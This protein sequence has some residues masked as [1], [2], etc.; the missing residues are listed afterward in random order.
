MTDTL[1]DRLRPALADRYDIDREVG[2]GGMA[3]VFRAR[4]VRH[5]RTVA[6]KVLH[7]EL[8]E[9]LGAERF[10]REVRITAR[11]AHPHILPLLDSGAADGLLFYVMPFVE[12]ETLRERIRREGELPVEE[13]LRYVREA[14]EALGYAHSLGIVHRDVKPENILL[15]GGHALIADFGIARAVDDTAQPLTYTGVSMG[16]PMYMSPEQAHGTSA[17]DA[18]SDQYSLGCVAYELLTGEPPFTGPNV[19]AITTRKLTESVPPLRGRRT[20][21]SAAVDAAITRALARSAADR[22]RTM[23]EFVTALDGGPVSSQETP[24]VAPPA[25]ASRVTGPRRV[26]ATVGGTLAV[27]AALGFALWTARERTAGVATE[28]TLNSIAVLPFDNLSADTAQA[29]FAQGLADELVTS[30]SMVEGVRVAS[31]TSTGALVR[32]GLDIAAIA[33][34]LNV[35]TVLEGSLR[36]SGDRIRVST[37]LVRVEGDSAIWSANYDRDADDVLKIQEEV[38]TAI[39]GALRG[40]LSA[41]ALDAVRSGT[42]DPE[43][44]DLYLQGIANRGRQTNASIEKAIEYFKAATERSPTFARAFAAMGSSYAVQGWY[45]YRPPKVAFPAALQAANEALR[46]DPRSA[47]AQATI[48]YAR[49]YYDWDLPAAE[50]EFVRALEMDPNSGLA[51]QWY[52]NYLAVAQRWDESEAAFRTAL[53]LE[54]TLPVRHAVGIWVAAHRGDYARSVELLAR[55]V[56]FDSTYASTYAW[57]AIGLEGLG[58]LDDAITA[59]QRAAMLSGQSPAVVASLARVHAVKGDSAQARAL[60]AR[61]LQAPVVPA[62]EVAK[63][64][65]ALGERAEAMRWLERA[66]DLRSHSMVFLRIDPQLAPLRGDAAFEALMKKVGI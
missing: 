63:V 54:P 30:L 35:Q 3:T 55:A 5:D 31:R 2:R 24:A 28:S 14:A 8:A 13:A 53:M 29:Y 15:Q 26:L 23:H 48:A 6:L 25:G 46:L 11:L 47:S 16:T 64:Y 41:G 65:L 10:L 42:D 49:L 17:V 4:D 50:R 20:S 52:G 36:V 38:A 27:V 21:V 22:F 19:M 45:D 59:L 7:P 44:Y 56:E 66:Y 43:A 57:G 37:R 51:H 40:K 9:A 61:V 32:Q 34:K 62:Y 12:G 18:R 39:V 1:L 60:L 33:E 58:R